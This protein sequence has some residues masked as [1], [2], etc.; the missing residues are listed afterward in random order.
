MEMLYFYFSLIIYIYSFPSFRKPFGLSEG[1]FSAAQRSWRTHRQ[2]G[3]EKYALYGFHTEEDFSEA[4][5]R[6]QIW[7]LSSNW[8]LCGKYPKW[9]GRQKKLNGYN[10]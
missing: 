4:S 6:C 2:I 3:K 9:Q 8:Y 5:D 1:Y 10:G 7:R